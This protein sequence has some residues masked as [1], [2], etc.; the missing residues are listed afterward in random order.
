MIATEYLTRDVVLIR[1]YKGEHTN[2][3]EPFCG[4]CVFCIDPVWPTRGWIKGMHGTI[5]RA[6]I[7]AFAEWLLTHGF[8]VAYAERIH[9][10]RL[11]GFVLC[12]GFQMTRAEWWTE[13][14]KLHPKGTT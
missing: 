12:E 14:F 11:P 13:R 8:D 4:T 5:G 3:Y 7:V 10:K 1:F 9:G 6:H 2:P